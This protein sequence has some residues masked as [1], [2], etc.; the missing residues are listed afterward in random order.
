VTVVPEVSNA[1]LAE[2]VDLSMATLLAVEQTL[3][4]INN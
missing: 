2:I 1:F 4:K 3:V